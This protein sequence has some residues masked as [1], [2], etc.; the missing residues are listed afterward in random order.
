MTKRHRPILLFLLGLEA[1]MRLAMIVHAGPMTDQGFYGDD[2][3]MSHQFSATIAAGGGITQAG[4]PSNGFQPLFV[5]MLVPLY[6]FLNLQQATVASAVLTSV[7]SVAGSYLLFRLLRDLFNPRVGLIG[8]GLWAVSAHLT[9]VGLNGLETSLANM[10]MLLLVYLHLRSVRTANRFLAT[11]A[12]VW[13]VVAGL[14]ILARMDLGLLVAL[15]GLDQIR[16]RLSRREYLPLALVVISGAL[17]ISPWFIWSR[18][19]CGSFVPVSGAATRTIAQLYGSPTGPTGHPAYFTLG[20]VPTDYYT[21]NLAHA[22]R[23]LLILAPAS[24]PA[25]TCAE[26]RA[27]V[28]SV[29]LALIIVVAVVGDRRRGQ[30]GSIGRK[31]WLLLQRLW[32]VWAFVPLLVGAYCFYYFAQW[33]FWRYLTPVTIVMILPSA[34]LID[35]IWGRFSQAGAGAKTLGIVCLAGAVLAGVAGH[36]R[37]FATPDP[38]GIAYRLYHDAIYVRDHLAS[39]D[40]IGSFESGTLDYFLDRDVFNL[41]G[42][43]NARAYRALVEGR[44]DRLV[45]ELDLD[46]VVS[47]PPLIRDL[48][49]RRGRWQPGRLRLVGHLSHVEIIAVVHAPVGAKGM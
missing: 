14:A 28:A 36:R 19:A 33:H 9:R 40:R 35:G 38:T 20:E 18:T 31:L 23:E 30:P 27:D 45:D 32:Y 41:D 1:A 4:Q 17:V 16:V 22:G 21:S 46:Y 2:S 29:W 10:M 34:V 7:F 24:A 13:G 48:L 39:R 8:L 12:A 37:L 25:M 47:S 11:D 49:D 5:F 43:T 42:K 15:V 26:G 6:W 3:F 44:M